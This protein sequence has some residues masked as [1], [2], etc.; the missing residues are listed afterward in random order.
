MPVILLLTYGFSGDKGPI[1][2]Q[3]AT[4]SKNNYQGLDP[5]KFLKLSGPLCHLVCSLQTE[6]Y[7]AEDTL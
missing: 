3:P 6:R 4:V 5:T 1:P 2:V 7:S